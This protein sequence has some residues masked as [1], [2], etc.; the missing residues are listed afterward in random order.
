MILR[1]PTAPWMLFDE[2]HYRQ[3]NVPRYWTSNRYG[4]TPLLS[5][6]L[7]LV[8]KSRPCYCVE[9]IADQTWVMWC[10]SKDEWTTKHPEA[11]IYR[12]KV[13][14]ENCCVQRRKEDGAAPQNEDYWV[15]EFTDEATFRRRADT[16]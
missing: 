9:T 16:W 11:T 3:P 8:V 2:S 15:L 13:A 6:V 7:A 10:S 12:S 1:N 14:A 4:L 5:N